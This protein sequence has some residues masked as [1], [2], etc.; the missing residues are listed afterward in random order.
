[1]NEKFKLIIGL[2]L[3]IILLAII[4]TTEGKIKNGQSV[5]LRKMFV[6]VA[7]I[8]FIMCCVGKAVQVNGWGNPLV[9]I[10][11]LLGIAALLL[12]IVFFAKKNINEKAA[13]RALYLIAVTKWGITTA[14]HII[15]LMK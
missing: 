6:I 2:I 13:L 10:C 15:N 9:V 3:G 1:M 12:I 5:N 8:S 7:L 11:V 14:H 4:I